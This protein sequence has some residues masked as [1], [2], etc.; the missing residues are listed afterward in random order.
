MITTAA[1]GLLLAFFLMLPVSKPVWEAIPGMAYLQFPW[2]FLN[3]FALFFAVL[4]S[5]C[6]SVVEKYLSPR[7]GI[8]ISA[9]IVLIT[10]G[11]YSRFFVPQ[12]IFPRDVS[13]YTDPV[14][15]GY[16]VTKRSDE[17][18]PSTFVPLTSAD[19]I[20]KQK[21][22]VP[23]NVHVTEITDKTGEYIAELTATT[24]ATAQLNIAYFPAWHV[25]ID[26]QEVPVTV[27][28]RG[29]SIR[30]PD[31]IHTLRVIFR[32]TPAE[33]AGNVLSLLGILSVILGIIGRKRYERQK[34][35]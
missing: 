17:Y 12:E 33:V 10:I 13:F 3:F 20:P 11:L 15:I 29:F 32:Q 7:I 34:T 18:L 26:R 35:S 31:G 24:S 2:R 22:V 27:A 16:T 14:S 21:L 4:L 5:V 8:G 30:V 6:M 25:L 9:G 1:V 28:P 23:D 19:D